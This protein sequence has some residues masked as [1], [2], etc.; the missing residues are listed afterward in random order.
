[1]VVAG[2]QDDAEL[3]WA[4]RGGGGNFGAVTSVTLAT[5]QLPRVLTGMIFVPLSSAK[6]SLVDL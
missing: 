2:E 3:F 6:A 1:M 4:L 5:H